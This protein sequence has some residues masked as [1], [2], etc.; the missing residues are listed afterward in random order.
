MKIVI[1]ANGFPDNHEPQWGC[2]ERDQALALEKEGH[3]VALLYVDRR[4]R[5]YWRKL[6]FTHKKVCNID[7]YGAFFIPT[8]GLIKIFGCRAYCWFVSKLYEFVY[9]RYICDHG[10]PDVIYAHYLW[11]IAYGANIMKK[12]GV[13]LVGIEHWSVLA[14]DSISSNVDYYGRVAYN[15]V[16]KLLVVSQFLQKHV[17][18]HFGIESTVVYDMLGPEFISSNTH[19]KS[20]NKVFKFIAVGSLLPIKQFAM[21]IKAFALS[22]LTDKGCCLMIVGD[23]P[24]RRVLEK[25]I[26]ELNLLNSVSL[27]GRRSKKEIVELLA[28]SNAFVLSSSSETFGVACIEA[29]SQGLPAIATECGGPEELINDK[30]GILVPKR[31]ENSL[32]E[33]MKYMFD[34]YNCYDRFAIAE[35]CRNRFA[36]QVIA[37]QL[38]KLFQEVVIK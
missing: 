5:T 32:S 30:N 11:N 36:S 16:N 3:D 26:Q 7:V 15:N 20:N 18:K 25:L 33:A 14:N 6:G 13:P 21:L 37:Q 2:F 29:L 35:E 23:G 12:Y 9:K 27:L 1:I 34:N 10:T 38:I 31:N 17:R 8:F 24:E 19:A 4:F 28:D 22:K